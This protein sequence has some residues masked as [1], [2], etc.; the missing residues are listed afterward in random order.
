MLTFVTNIKVCVSMRTRISVDDYV[1]GVLAGDRGILGKAITLVESI[2]ETDRTLAD[3]LIRQILPHSGNS[4]RIGISGIPGAGKSTFIQAL[5]N[6]MLKEEKS[7]AV[8]AIDPSSSLSHGSIL[9][10]KTRMEKLAQD[11]RVFIRPTPAGSKL[12]GISR[13]TPETIL[14]CEAAGYHYI[15]VETVGV[16]QSESVVRNVTDF[17]ILL[18]IAGAGDEMQGIKR[19]I[20]EI[21]DLVI[22][23][24]A[25]G[26][27]IDRVAQTVT[28]LRN[29][30]PL[31]S[32]PFSGLHPDVLSCS[33]ITGYGISEIWKLVEDFQSI[34][35]SNGYLKQNRH[36]Q[37]TER[38]HN[39][40]EA[41]LK[42][43]FYSTRNIKENIQVTEQN[44]KLG[45]DTPLLAAQ[46]LVQA[47]LNQY[48]GT[49]D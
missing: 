47:F 34:S 17:F 10:D 48:N 15:M 35:S 9:A 11:R 20:M 1:H 2:L 31:M 45:L 36:A 26:D 29:V 8:L 3:E 18:L 49:K 22:V 23:N 6:E 33:S 30:L 19:G 38:L 40:I 44:L 14:L 46:K 32:K 12:G 37:Q 16:G 7:L 42:E 5:G 28:E 41:L 27:N 21:A 24:K 13:S 43:K 4:F 39:D 25:D